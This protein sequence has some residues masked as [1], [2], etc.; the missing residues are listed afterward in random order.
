MQ[1][2]WYSTLI[3]NVLQYFIESVLNR[4]RR[5][6]TPSISTTSEFDLP[7][8]YRQTLNDEP[9][10]CTDRFIRNKRMLLFATD[11]QLET[12]FSSE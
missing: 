6:T 12:L 7:D 5:H 9:F 4:T 2:S 3:W 11:K 1:V 10:V 8:F